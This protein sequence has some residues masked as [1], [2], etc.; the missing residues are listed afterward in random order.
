VITR[1]ERAP[2]RQH[3][4][5]QAF[6]SGPLHQSFR[7]IGESTAGKRP[8]Q[9]LGRAVESQLALHPHPQLTAAFLEFPAID[10]AMRG[11]AEIDTVVFDEVLRFF[12]LWVRL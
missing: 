7:H 1:I 6:C 4:L 9:Q 5:Q 10:V 8:V 2:I 12:R 3:P 11:Q